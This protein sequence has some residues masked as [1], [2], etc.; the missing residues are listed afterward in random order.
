[1]IPLVLLL[2]FLW[3]ILALART[4]NEFHAGLLLF[5][6]SLLVRV[7]F[8]GMW[9]FHQGWG[10]DWNQLQFV[11][12][13]FYVEYSWGDEVDLFGNIYCLVVYLLQ[14]LGF[15][16]RDLKLL[17]IF[18]TSLALVRLYSLNDLVANKKTYLQYLLVLGSLSHLHV[19]YY[20]V[21]VL[22]DG[23]I[24]LVSME[25]LV[26]AIR[27]KT[28]HRNLPLL[29]SIFVL[30]WLRAE[31]IC[32]LGIFV[33][34]QDWRL[35]RRDTVLVICLLGGLFILG[36]EF[37]EGQFFKL[38]RLGLTYVLNEG[39]GTQL[40]DLDTTREFLTANPRLYGILAIKGFMAVLSPFHQEGL[41]DV[42]ILLQFYGSV[43][44]FLILARKRPSLWCM[45]PILVF[46][47]MVLVISAC[48]F[49]TLRWALYPYS[50]LIYSLLFLSCR[51]REDL[52][53]WPRAPVLLLP[54]FPAQPV[55][56]Q[57]RHEYR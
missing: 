19:I 33:F 17:N 32:L 36:Q 24:F 28:N 15:T 42:L 43:V 21:F 53:P 55:L 49:A 35:K 1:M 39:N 44:C 47:L 13:T 31:M 40:V 37:V 52:L 57:L 11:D 30:C 26:Q 14:D 7:A 25:V 3:G 50:T 41:I 29:L 18:A 51:P 2:T 56:Q 22:K 54:S 4:K 10:G 12:E 23:L 38:Y 27:R 5:A 45:S 8:L 6:T 34:N 46:P 16:P 20:S 9:S 48:T